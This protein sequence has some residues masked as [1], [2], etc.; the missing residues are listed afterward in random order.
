MVLLL[1][2]EFWKFH[3]S[4]NITSDDFAEKPICYPCFAYQTPVGING[5][6]QVAYLYRDDIEKMAELMKSLSNHE[7]GRDA[8]K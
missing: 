2:E 1:N 8:N 7:I 6:S 5:N 4:N 3:V